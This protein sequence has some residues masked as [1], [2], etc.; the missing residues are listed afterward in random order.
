M[1]GP[2]A[3]RNKAPV[4][5]VSSWNNLAVQHSARFRYKVSKAYVVGGL[6]AVNAPTANAIADALGIRRP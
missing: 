6:N 3:G 5:L 4:L 1:A 2:L